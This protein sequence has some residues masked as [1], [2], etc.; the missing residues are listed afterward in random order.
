[1]K[2]FV[3]NKLKVFFCTYS[4]EIQEIFNNSIFITNN[5]Q[6]SNYFITCLSNETNY[7]KY[8]NQEY[9][10]SKKKI[11]NLNKFIDQYFNLYAFQKIVIFYHTPIHFKSNVITVCYCKDDIDKYN[12]LIC[13]PAIQIYNFNNNINKKYFVSFKGNLISPDKLLDNRIQIFNKLK[14]YN[15]DKIIIIDKQN[16][17]YDYN[18]L[19]QNSLFGIII[20]GDLPWSYRLTECINAGMIPIIIKPKNKN[21]FAFDE[22]I[23]YSLFSIIINSDEIDYLMNTI[24]VNLSTEKIKSMLKNLE[25]VNIKYF[26]S[27][28]QQMNGVIEILQKRL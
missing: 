24:L 13:P 11:K 5:F 12:I 27:R 18:E 23:D 10:K 6:E 17:T 25:I 2:L 21:I 4:K 16:N 15:N 3:T 20:E 7:P 26:I 9:A 14:K 22:L 1:M 8:G 19:M 28:K